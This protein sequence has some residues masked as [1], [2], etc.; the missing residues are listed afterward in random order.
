MLNEIGIDLPLLLTQIVNF[1]ILAWLLKKL[2]YQPLLEMIQS[3]QEEIEKGLELRRE[4]EEKRKRLE[5]EKKRIL[6]ETREEAQLLIEKKKKDANE[7]KEKIVREGREE[8]VELIEQGKKEVRAQKRKMRED[9]EEEIVDTA[10]ALTRKV[11]RDLLSKKDQ[12]TIIRKEL[13]RLSA[14]AFKTKK[15]KK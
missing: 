15:N 4:M 3:R 6:Q 2:L 11:L 5:E 1:L 10:A 7:I 12:E 9:I 14:A 13:D 8:K